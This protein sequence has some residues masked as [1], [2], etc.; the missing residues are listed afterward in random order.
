MRIA[1]LTVQVPFTTGGAEIHAASLKRELLQRGYEADIITVPFKWYPPEQLMDCMMMARLMDV[2]EVN[3]EKIHRVIAL[4][5]PAYFAA[6]SHKVLWILHQHRQAY[7]LFGTPFSDLSQTD[8]GR[9]V[10][11]EIKRWDDHF[12][13]QSHAIYANSK[14]V[15][16]RLLHFNHIKATPLYHPPANA[17]KLRCGNFDN[18][19]FYPGRFDQIKRQ[20]LIVEAFEH[21]P[22]NL[23]L[24]LTGQSD[25]VYGR[26]LLKRIESS[27]ASDRI[28]V[29]GFVT[30][31]KILELYA[32]CLAVYNGVYDEDYGYLTLEAFYAG[33][34]VITHSDSGGPLEFVRQGVNGY[35]TPPNA[36]DLARCLAEIAGNPGRLRDLGQ[37]ARQSIDQ[38]HI[39][40]DYVIERLLS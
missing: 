31:E 13:P 14:T 36:E 6:H 35:I 33:K 4:K 1:I 5:F 7:D 11:E 32:N 27:P 18:Y 17:E 12:L 9:K 21:G 16:N 22:K 25:S 38:Q 2:E 28:R 3:G 30:E 20:H 24:V 23:Q 39:T 10:A 19:I 40:W 15:A 34:P 29:L 26:S 8:S 37:M